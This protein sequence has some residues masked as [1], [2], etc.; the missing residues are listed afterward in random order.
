[1]IIIKSTEP[2]V[3]V[4]LPVSRTPHRANPLRQL[5]SRY[6]GGTRISLARARTQ[7]YLANILILKT[8]NSSF[9]ASENI[10]IIFPA[11][12]YRCLFITCEKNRNIER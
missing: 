5:V 3:S 11:N 8:S 10:H 6:D 4:H 9:N 1:M 7:L 12:I 2:G